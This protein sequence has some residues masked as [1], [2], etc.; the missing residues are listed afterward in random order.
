[1]NLLPALRIGMVVPSSNTC[2]EPMTT[3]LLAGRDDVAI[4]C[5]RLGVTRIAM[6]A[7]SDDQFSS[8][9]MLEAA[10][11]LA[12]ARVDLIVWNGTAG[13]WLGFEHDRKL[14]AL[15]EGETGVPATTSALALLAA[16]KRMD[17]R[18]VGLA[19]PYTPDVAHKIAGCLTEEGFEIA[20]VSALGLEENFAF[21]TLTE[22]QVAHMLRDSSG[23][24]TDA[25]AVVCTNV[26]AAGVGADLEADLGAVVCDS[27]AVTLWHALRLV[28]APA[29]LPG[30]GSLYEEED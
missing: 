11:Q 21:A 2:L 17:A 9:A 15:I 24:G 12:D 10:R 19:L 18:R 3:R 16:L 5:S 23:P 6:D 20:A 4:H 13:T 8:R 30:W 22:E 26:A 1:M 7:S 29:A 27:V 25:I 14:C 28:G